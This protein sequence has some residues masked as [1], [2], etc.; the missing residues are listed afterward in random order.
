MR[1]HISK[2]LSVLIMT[3]AYSA[4]SE[5]LPSVIYQLDSNFTHHVMVVEKST[6]SLYLYENNQGLPKLLKKYTIMTGK[7]PGDKQVQGDKKT[8]EGIYFFQ[9]FHASQELLKKYGDYGKIYGAGAFTLNYPNEIDRR[10]GKTGGGIWLH[11][12]DDDNRISL[13]LDSKGCVVAVD[14]DLK[15]LSRYIDLANTP[16][17]IVENLSFLNLESWK[18]QKESLQNVV[19]SWMEAWQKKDF[20]TYINQYSPREFL[21][22]RKGNYSAYKTYKKAVFSRADEPQIL[23]SDVSIL[24]NNDY[25]VVTMKQDYS[26]SVIRDIGKKVLYLKK[27]DR[28]EWKIV[29]EKWSK[30]D[31]EQNIA[32]TPKMRYFT[33][34]TKELANDSGSI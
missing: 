8:P 5:F 33:P 18:T 1:R 32:F 34:A 31:Q 9:N 12:S 29:S 25:A 6:H 14:K 16:M 24:L 27:N 17:V 28:Y 2:L 21:D 19:Y 30:L 20:K 15:D 11:S 10:E 26:S 4:E 23:F 22:N 7:F 3:C 13:G